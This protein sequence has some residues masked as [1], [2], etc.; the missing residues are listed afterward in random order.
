MGIRCLN[1]FLKKQCNPSINTVGLDSLYGKKI[2][3]DANIYMFD[4]AINNELI[5]S[6]YKMI[7]LFRYY[8][9]TPIYVFDGKTNINKLETLEKRR[10]DKEIA[11]NKYN[12]MLLIKDPS[13][14]DMIALQKKFTRITKTQYD[15]V[16]QLMTYMGVNYIDSEYEGD[17][18]CAYLVLSNQVHGC[19]SEDTDMF[20]YGCN[21]IFKGLDLMNHTVVK[22]DLNNI[23]YNLNINDDNFKQLCVISGTDYNK[24]NKGFYYYYNIYKKFISTPNNCVTF[25]EWLFYN[26]YKYNFNDLLR[27][28]SM[29]T[30]KK[31]FE[32]TNTNIKNLKNNK[33]KRN[34]LKI[35]LKKYNFIF[36]D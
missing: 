21:Y 1:K 12:E 32:N 13:D 6:F 16:K 28:Y 27:V 8:N 23:L 3:V 14:Q 17:E 7:S 11:E 20:V 15:E 10:K 9:I 36:I 4:F 5:E 25:Y 30:R 33:I 26:N 31:V 2:V 34:E 22:Y 35:L 19:L 18:L 29:Y 24:N